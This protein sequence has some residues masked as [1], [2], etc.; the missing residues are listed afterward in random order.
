MW[1]GEA[2]GR[3]GEQRGGGNTLG[4]KERCFIGT[5]YPEAARAI[6]RKEGFIKLVIFAMWKSGSK[7]F[8]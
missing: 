3:V 6:S 4:C 7:G 8:S 1:R 5:N 2:G